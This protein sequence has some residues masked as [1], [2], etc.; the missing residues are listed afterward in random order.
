MSGFFFFQAV[1]SLKSKRFA[2]LSMNLTIW[3]ISSAKFISVKDHYYV[4]AMS[5]ILLKKKDGKENK[6]IVAFS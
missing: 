6:E 1:N 2:L 5:D 3:L 4:V